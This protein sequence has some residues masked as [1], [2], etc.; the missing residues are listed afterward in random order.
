MSK[1]HAKSEAASAGNGDSVSIRF[2]GGLV[3]RFTDGVGG[4]FVKAIGPIIWTAL[5]VGGSITVSQ[6]F[7]APQTNPPAVAVPYQPSERSDSTRARMYLLESRINTQEGDLKETKNEI[8]S[9]KNDLS[10]MEGKIDGILQAI[11]SNR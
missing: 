4:F 8:T 1:S 6:K 10:R 7:A 5:G 9:F 2:G 3:R 11:K